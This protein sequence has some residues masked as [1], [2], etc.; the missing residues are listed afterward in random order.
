MNGWKALASEAAATKLAMVRV[1]QSIR[2][3]GSRQAWNAWEAMAAE[4]GAAKLAAASVL[5]SMRPEGRKKRAAWNSWL[6]TRG[7][8]PPVSLGCRQAKKIFR[9]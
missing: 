4:R 2:M 1:A 6:R 8:W 9:G 3:R 7:V 5:N